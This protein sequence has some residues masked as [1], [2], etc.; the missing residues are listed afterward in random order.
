MLGNIFFDCLKAFISL[1]LN[2][3]IQF[4]FVFCG[5]KLVDDITI[6]AFSLYKDWILQKTEVSC[7]RQNGTDKR[8]GLIDLS[9]MSA[10]RSQKFTNCQELNYQISKRQ[11]VCKIDYQTAS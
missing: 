2:K 7:P 9:H 5:D 11:I 1:N 4:I 10:W 6:L 8:L 3:E